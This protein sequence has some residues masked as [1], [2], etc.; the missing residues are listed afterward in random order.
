MLHGEH[1]T[2]RPAREADVDAVYAAHLEIRN[3]G[4]SSS[5]V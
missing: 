3:R 4:A 2:L 1:V 5:S